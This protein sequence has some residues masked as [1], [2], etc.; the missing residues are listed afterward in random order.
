MIKRALVTVLAAAGLALTASAPAL[1]AQPYPINF[2]NFPLGSYASVS[3]TT[4]SGGTATLASTGLG[5]FTYTDPFANYSGDG[6]DG[7]GPYQSGSWTS[8]DKPVSFG[9][10]ELV[11]SW[12]ATTPDGTWIQVEM[13]PKMLDG[14]WAKWYILGRWSS[15][16]GD[17]HRTSVGGQGD[18]DGFVSID[19]FFAKDHVAVAYRLRVTLFRR[20]GSSAS[21]TL[22]RLSAVAMNLTNQK[23]TFPSRTDGTTGDLNLPTYSQEIHHGDFPQYDNGGEAWC[24]P[25]STSMV[26]RYWGLAYQPTP[27]E[28]Q[29]VTDELGATHNDPWVDFTARA[30]YDYHYNG[31]GNW[32][33]NAAYAASRG[34]VADV[35]ALHNLREA[36]PYIQA[37]VPLVASVAW[38]S[39]K[40]EGGIKS[41]NGHLM[42]IGG[43]TAGGNV[44]AYDPA[45]DTDAQV[46]HVYDREQFER[47]WIPASGGIVYVIRT[48]GTNLD[49]LLTANN[50]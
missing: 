36:E 48:A 3:G 27:A 40:L 50:S 31:A 34:L 14:H 8:P 47:A 43:F 13:Q 23:N 17:F 5:S 6:A 15:S 10:N 46:R 41:T 16:D 29:W 24:S 18:A 19:T 38:N 37:G 4:V 1:A 45:S 28:Y 12:N 49:S 20:D 7:S 22:T 39:N 2:K 21:P 25:T 35:A 11:A 9:F 32:P 44:I 33:F 42:A 26:V 30:V